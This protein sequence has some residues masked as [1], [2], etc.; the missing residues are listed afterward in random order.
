MRSDGTH[1]RRLAR[2][3]A[4]DP[5]FSPNGKRLAYTSRNGPG[6]RIFTTSPS[7]KGGREPVV[8]FRGSGEG[9]PAFIGN[10]RIIY[11]SFDGEGFQLYSV[12]VDG[13]HRRQLTHGD[14]ESVNTPDVSPDRRRVT[15]VDSF[16]DEIC[17]MKLA[18]TQR[19]CF[20][21]G[22]VDDPNEL[23]WSKFSPDGRKLLFWEWRNGVFKTNRD[24]SRAIRLTKAGARAPD[25]GPR[26]E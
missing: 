15:F 14:E 7:G 12:R 24:G 5:A 10:R 18:G 25:W 17:V 9:N 11:T 19:H 4:S 13:T 23:L 26:A 6:R 1:V 22:G 20:V 8:S 2:G 21:P 3:S 16:T